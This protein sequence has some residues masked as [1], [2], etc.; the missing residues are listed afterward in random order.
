[1]LATRL[2][3]DYNAR[4]RRGRGPGREVNAAGVHAVPDEIGEGAGA[5]EELDR[6]GTGGGIVWAGGTDE[7]LHGVEGAAAVIT[8]VDA[9]HDKGALTDCLHGVGEGSRGAERARRCEGFQHRPV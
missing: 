2:N 5:S 1:M 4:V 3:P 7:L 9:P 6:S 8:C